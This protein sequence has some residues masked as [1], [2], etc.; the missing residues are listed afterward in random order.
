MTD[1]A[2]GGAQAAPDGQPQA[3]NAA[4]QAGAAG[5]GKP[6]TT[7]T[8][9]T[10]GADDGAEPMSLDEARKLRSENKSL[11]DRLKPLEEAKAHADNAALSEVERLQRERETLAAENSTLKAER[12]AR[13][14][15]DAAT[16]TARR[17]GFRNPDLAHRLIDHSALVLDDEGKP[18]NLDSL[19]GEVAKANPYLI[20]GT[21]DFG[22]GPRGGAA[23]PNNDVNTMI[24]RAAGRT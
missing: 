1:A 19:L 15:A 2:A 3:G 8:T 5:D 11:R 13:A 12:Q 18:K 20:N 10:G 9:T 6:T 22:G 17:L 23:T 7:T 21:T 24:R 14:L 4:P 16:A